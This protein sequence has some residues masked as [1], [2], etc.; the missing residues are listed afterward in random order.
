MRRAGDRQRFQPVIPANAVFLM[1]HEV[2]LGDLRRFGDELVG[3]LAAARRSADALAEQVLLAHQREFIGDKATL[4]AQRDQRHRA[5]RLAADR[6]PTI[7]LRG[8]L[9][10][11][12]A[13]QVG[14]PLA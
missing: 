11:V 6:R 1:H 13:Q 10:A 14:E 3:A 8:V 2:A 9:E 12:L 7:L 5:H 4:D